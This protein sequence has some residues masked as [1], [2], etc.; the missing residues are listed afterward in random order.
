[1]V[2]FNLYMDFIYLAFILFMWWIKI[3]K[4][5][6]F[7]PESPRW[8][9]SQNYHVKAQKILDKYNEVSIKSPPTAASPTFV[10]QTQLEESTTPNNK[11]KKSIKQYFGS[12]NILFSDSILRRKI[13][14]MYFSFFVSISVGYCLSKWQKNFFFHYFPFNYSHINNFELLFQSSVLT[15]STQ[16]V[17]FTWQ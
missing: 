11:E 8:L 7:I 2:N 16:I 5:N 13:L 3:Y 9:I 10:L 6:R 17:I 4:F 1:M 15:P 14:I 12:M